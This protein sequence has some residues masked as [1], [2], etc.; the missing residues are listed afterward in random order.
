MHHARVPVTPRAPDARAA[1]AVRLVEQ[2][3]ARRRER[4]VAGRRQVVGDPLDAWLVG[5]GRPGVLLR[6]VALG[7]VLA[8]VAV[9]LVQPLRLR[10]P[11]LELVVAERPGRRDPVDVF[12]LTEVLRPQPVQRGAVELGR[13]TDEVV[14]LGLERRAVGVVP[15]IRRDVLAVDEHGLGVPVLR[16]PREEVAAFE[17]QDPLPRPGEGVGERPSAGPR[18]DDDDVVVLGHRSLLDWLDWSTADAFD[19]TAMS[20]GH[21]RPDGVNWAPPAR[22]G[23]GWADRAMG[24]AST[25][26]NT[27]RTAVTRNSVDRETASWSAPPPKAARPYPIW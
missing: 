22:A 20:A 14:D 15:R 9:H 7:R 10:V 26:M 19:G 11:G 16:L 13:P 4:V 18:P 5:D 25:P 1:R 2:D 8:V 6:P 3:P 23:D 21:H 12:D 17:Q 24:R 27:A